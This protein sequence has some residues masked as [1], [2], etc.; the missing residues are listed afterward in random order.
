MLLKMSLNE[1]LSKIHVYPHKA[2]VKTT[3]PNV[4]PLEISISGTDDSSP[5]ASDFLAM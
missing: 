2:S 5:S 1:L 4:P 3:L